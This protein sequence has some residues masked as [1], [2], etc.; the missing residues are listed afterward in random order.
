MNIWA[1]W[2]ESVQRFA[3]GLSDNGG[4]EITR[5]RHLAL[6]AGESS[7]QVIVVGDDGRPELQEQPGPTDEA[8]RKAERAWRTVELSR[9]EWVVTRHRDEQDMGGVTSLTAEQYAELL[10][11]RQALRDWPAVDAFP[12]IAERPS[13]PEWLVDLTQ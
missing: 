10:N 5:E 3:F 4:L 1:K 13:P 6:L 8:L 11:H 12:V 2:D 7:G 9:H